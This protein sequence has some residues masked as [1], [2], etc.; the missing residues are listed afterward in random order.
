ML[1]EVMDKEPGLPELWAWFLILG[2]AGLLLGRYKWWAGLFPAVLIALL[3]AGHIAELHDPSIGPDILAEAGRGYFVQS[4]IAIA[5][6][7]V[8]SS[9]GIILGWKRYRQRSS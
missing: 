8:M 1:L 6:A 4:Y 3:A 7:L 5:A 2:L 9:A